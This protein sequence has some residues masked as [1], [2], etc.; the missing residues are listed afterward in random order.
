VAAAVVVLIIAVAALATSTVLIARER[1]AARAEAD[2][3]TAINRFLVDDLLV[4]ADPEKADLEKDS[5][6]EQVTLRQVVDRAAEKVGTRFRGRPLLEAALRITLGDTY[7]GLGAWTDSRNQ[8]AA[9]LAIYERE[10]G[11]GAAET[12][13]AAGQLGHALLHEVR[14]PE[15]EPLLRRS[16]DGV[17]RVLGDRHPDTLDA[18]SSLAIVYRNLGQ[19][20]EAERLLVKALD[21]SRRTLGEEHSNTLGSMSD[22]A[23]RD[24]P[25]AIHETPTRPAV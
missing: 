18:M 8:A 25:S 11:P 3:A 10:K 13:N 22:L 19:M 16:L 17:R 15:A 4:Q 21:R 23:D 5:P 1:A 7:H 6:T 24:D 2:K 14:Y 12:L 9:A 20:V